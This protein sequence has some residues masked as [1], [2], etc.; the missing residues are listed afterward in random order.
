M[1]EMTLTT[2]LNPTAKEYTPPHH[3]ETN[4]SH[5]N[6]KQGIG[7]EDNLVDLDDDQDGGVPLP[8]PPLAEKTK[9]R[10]AQLRYDDYDD[11]EYFTI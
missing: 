11:D 6:G 8:K 2:N 7:K 1:R 4:K 5:S 3:R 10:L 9:T